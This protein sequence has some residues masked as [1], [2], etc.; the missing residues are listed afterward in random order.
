MTGSVD[1]SLTLL[2][3]VISPKNGPA[4][5][6]HRREDEDF[7]EL[8]PGPVGPDTLASLA[9]ANW[10]EFVGPQLKDSDPL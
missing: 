7:A 1:G 10:S 8:L 5:H 4:L 9:R 6:V 3:L 2:E